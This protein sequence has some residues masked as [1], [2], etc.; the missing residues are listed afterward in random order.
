MGI[1]PY[2]SQSSLQKLNTQ[3]FQQFKDNALKIF[4]QFADDSVQKSTDRI[5]QLLVS[6]LCEVLE[7]DLNQDL[8]S[9]CKNQFSL[10]IIK[11]G[12]MTFSHYIVDVMLEKT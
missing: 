12:M 4:N 5:F 1:K 6:N 11:S 9:I 7:V 2:S 3:D 8:D 10:Q